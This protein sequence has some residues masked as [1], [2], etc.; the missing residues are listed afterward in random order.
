MCQEFSAIGLVTYTNYHHREAAQLPGWRH[1]S[2]SQY[3]EWST[4][5]LPAPKPSG[6]GVAH[7][8]VGYISVGH[9]AKSNSSAFT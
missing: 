8:D 1:M 7:G 4:W 5:E 9:E 3:I 2:W 6:L